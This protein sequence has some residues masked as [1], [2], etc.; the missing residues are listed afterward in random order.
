[1]DLAVPH[2]FGR[3]DWE[4]MEFEFSRMG[5]FKRSARKNGL[6]CY[7]TCSS[8]GRHPTLA[9]SFSYMWTSYTF[10]TLKYAARLRNLGIGCILCR[11][12]KCMESLSRV[13]QLITL[14]HVP[15]SILNG[16][17][18]CQLCMASDLPR[19]AVY[20]RRLQRQQLN[21]EWSLLNSPN[22]EGWLES[23]LSLPATLLWQL[24]PDSYT[25]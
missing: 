11:L 8:R 23:E 13:H 22:S 9:S 20:A 17:P 21:V 19:P 7:T 12:D 4:E 3:N 24:N 16:F 10:F 2:G 6:S 18:N 1:M 15:V 5:T 14:G 25:Q